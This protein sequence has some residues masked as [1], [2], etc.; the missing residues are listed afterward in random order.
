MIKNLIKDALIDKLFN[1]SSIVK[2]ADIDDSVY[3]IRIPG[4]GENLFFCRNDIGLICQFDANHSTV[5][6]NTIKV[7]S[8]GKK[9][10]KK[11]REILLIKMKQY[12]QLVYQRELLVLPKF[13]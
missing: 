9:I 6:A 3:G 13:I 7:W 10:N 5:F 12:Y 8:N 4:R 11:E 2:H 1:D